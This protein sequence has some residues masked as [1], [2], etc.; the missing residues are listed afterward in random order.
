VFFT[1]VGLL[2]FAQVFM[3]PK[4]APMDSSNRIGH[5]RLVWFALKSPQRFVEYEPWLKYDEGDLMDAV[6]EEHLNG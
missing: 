6:D 3:M 2:T 1:L 5:L 4:R